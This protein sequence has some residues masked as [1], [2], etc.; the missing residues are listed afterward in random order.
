LL[1]EAI[2]SFEYLFSSNAKNLDG[3]ITLKSRLSSANFRFITE[4]V[5]AI[6]FNQ[7]RNIILPQ[8]NDPSITTLKDLIYFDLAFI[9]DIQNYFGWT[10]ELDFKVKFYLYALALF[11]ES[12]ITASIKLNFLKSNISDEKLNTSLNKYLELHRELLGLSYEKIIYTDKNLN[13]RFEYDELIRKINDLEKNIVSEISLLNKEEAA[14]FFNQSLLLDLETFF[15]KIIFPSEQIIFIDKNPNI[16]HLVIASVSNTNG[17]LDFDV[18]SIE[19]NFDLIESYSNAFTT[20]PPPQNFESMQLSLADLFSNYFQTCEHNSNN[21]ISFI[22]SDDLRNFP[23]HT[24]KVKKNDGYEYLIEK[25]TIGYLPSWQSAHFLKSD[26]LLISDKSFFGIG[27]PNFN[28]E[29]TKNYANRG[30]ANLEGLRGLYRLSETE[31]EV[32]TISNLFKSKKLFLGDNA[33]ENEIKQHPSFANS[34]TYF[35]THSVPLLSDISLQPGLALTPPNVANSTDDG[36]LTPIEITQM[37]FSNSYI[38]LAACRTYQELYPG[39]EKFSAFAESFF[40]AGAKGVI[41]SMWDIE[42]ISAAKFNKR[43]YQEIFND[44]LSFQE[45]IRKVSLEFISDKQYSHPFFWGAYIY[46]GVY[47]NPENTL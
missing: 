25:C 40:S 4:Q 14:N 39:S 24:L 37:D 11:D 31:E 15:S 2:Y 21:K 8:A 7:N 30:V 16:N 26:R 1:A 42:T 28:E 27:N 5:S 3:L 47:N 17:K 45:A 36:L 12:N 6:F 38:S 19:V 29:R 13:F 41:I 23:I 34:I 43:M 20:Y 9:S 35:A 33:N 10:D 46:L 18:A 22:L 32:S 44:G